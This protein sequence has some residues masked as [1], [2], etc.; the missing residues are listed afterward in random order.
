MDLLLPDPNLS[1]MSGILLL[2]CIDAG[3]QISQVQKIRIIMYTE[4]S[5]EFDIEVSEICMSS[6][7]S[8]LYYFLIYM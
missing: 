5:L 7:L 6:C 3:I 4:Y 2:H 8:F 1:K